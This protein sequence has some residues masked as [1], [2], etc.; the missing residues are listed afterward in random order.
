MSGT[1]ALSPVACLGDRWGL[2]WWEGAKETPLP[3]AIPSCSYLSGALGKHRGSR[4][5]CF[6]ARGPQ[7]HVRQPSRPLWANPTVPWPFNAAQP[8]SPRQPGAA[9]GP[10]P[11]WRL[12]GSLAPGF[13]L[14]FRA[15]ALPATGRSQRRAAGGPRRGREL[16]GTAGAGSLRPWDHRHHRLRW[17]LA[18]TEAACA[19]EAMLWCR[20]EAGDGPAVVSRSPSRRA[21]G[22]FQLRP[23]FH[24]PVPV[25]AC[26]HLGNRAGSHPC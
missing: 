3:C 17:G 24:F 6:H 16:H 15:A 12:P 14:F 8:G 2:G 19:A 7:P 13:L 11:G 23:A 21:G 9:A 18:L 1:A 4:S 10:S 26:Q 20:E 22:Y 5:P 25:A